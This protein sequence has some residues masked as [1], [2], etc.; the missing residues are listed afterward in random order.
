MI[1]SD[2]QE[3]ILPW[4]RTESQQTSAKELAQIRHGRTSAWDSDAPDTTGIEGYESILGAQLD[5]HKKRAEEEESFVEEKKRKSWSCERCCHCVFYPLF[6]VGLCIGRCLLAVYS[7]CFGVDPSL[8]TNH[9]HA[10]ALSFLGVS[11]LE[12]VYMLTAFG[13][14]DRDG[15]G[16]MTIDEFLDKIGMPWSHFAEKVFGVFDADDSGEI[17][18]QE[19]AFA[20]WNYCTM[21]KREIVS[22]TFDCYSKDGVMHH[23]HIEDLLIDNFTHNYAEASAT[24]AGS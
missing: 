24:Q 11:P 23:E 17:D 9:G 8:F 21:T 18:F 13:K 3:L 10:A 16:A 20:I 5:M 1:L 7:R 12:Q 6:L 2:G 22:F 19:W 14:A 15:S 4:S